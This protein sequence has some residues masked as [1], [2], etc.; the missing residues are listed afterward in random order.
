M[1]YDDCPYWQSL[2]GGPSNGQ[3]NQGC[4]IEPRCVV[5]RGWDENE[6]EADGR[7][8]RSL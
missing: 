5:D 3:C 6:G 1:S 7:D 2:N 8:D 4:W